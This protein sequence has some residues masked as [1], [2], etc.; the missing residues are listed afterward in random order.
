MSQI[1][2]LPVSMDM[3]HQATQRD[4][5]LLRVLEHT[6]QGWPTNCEEELESYY[7]QKD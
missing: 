4:P 2:V 3:I 7:R 5:V 1:D 6:K